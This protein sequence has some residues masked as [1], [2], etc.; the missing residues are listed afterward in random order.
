[1]L[2][3][4]GRDVAFADADGGKKKMVLDVAVAVLNEDGSQAGGA[5]ETVTMALSNEKKAEIAR[6]SLQ[7]TLD[8]SVTRP[9][10]YQVRAVVRDSTSGELGST[11]AFLDIPDF[12]QPQI[13]LSSLVLSLPEGVRA[14]RGARPEWNEFAPGTAVQYLCEVFGLKTPGKPPVPPNVETEVKLYR[15]G[16]PVAS[17]PASPVEIKNAGDKLFLS[18]SMRIPDD[19]A[20]GNYTMEVLAYDRLEASKKKQ[21]AQQWIDVTV[22]PA[23]PKTAVAK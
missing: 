8:V 2:D 12:N 22:V 5:N 15:G 19:L 3:I 1:V 16:G 20:P 21:V 13:S 7:Y 10:P 6:T 23:E 14:V 4:D 11:Y 9:G 17:V 18:G